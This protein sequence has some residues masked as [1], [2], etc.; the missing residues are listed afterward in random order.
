[1]KAP[2]A[3]AR[4]TETR[5]KPAHKH[6][7]IAKKSAEKSDDEKLAAEARHE[8]L[9]VAAVFDELATTI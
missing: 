3:R 5:T 2:I 9:R 8:Q 4:A 1:M 7:V 6:K